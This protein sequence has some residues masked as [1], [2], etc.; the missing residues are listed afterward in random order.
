VA[1]QDHEDRMG[2]MTSQPKKLNA[3]SNSP[4]SR[5]DGTGSVPHDDLYCTGMEAE[6]EKGMRGFFYA[7]GRE[8]LQAR[9]RIYR[10]NRSR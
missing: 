7:R 8:V 5:S 3:G 6:T 1:F 2:Q 4:R 9:D 10:V